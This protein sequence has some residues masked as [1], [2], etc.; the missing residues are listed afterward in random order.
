MQSLYGHMDRLKALENDPGYSQKAKIVEE[1]L[2]VTENQF[3]TKRNK[4]KYDNIISKY[5][6]NLPLNRFQRRDGIPSYTSLMKNEVQY[7]K[8][9]AV[10]NIDAIRNELHERGVNF[11]ISWKWKKLISLLKENETTNQTG[12]SQP[13]KFFKPKNPDHVR[14]F[15]WIGSSVI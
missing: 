2:T 8:L 4:D 13:M 6:Q 15:K 9:K 12:S 14:K 5:H 1:Q 3:S 10:D 7:G 11:D